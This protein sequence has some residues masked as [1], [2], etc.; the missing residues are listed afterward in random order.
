MAGADGFLLRKQPSR[1]LGIWDGAA[2]WAMG[3]SGNTFGTADFAAPTLH[4]GCSKNCR[5]FIRL[6]C[7]RSIFFL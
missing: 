3:N 7:R 5:R 1:L 2:G 6:C 4:G